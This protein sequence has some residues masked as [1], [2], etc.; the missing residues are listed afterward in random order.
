MLDILNEVL[1][2]ICGHY[3]IPFQVVVM[4]IFRNLRMAILNLRCFRVTSHL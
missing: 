2:L 4:L 3:L 1:S